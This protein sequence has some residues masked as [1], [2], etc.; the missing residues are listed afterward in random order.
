MVGPNG[1]GQSRTCPTPCAG[2]WA[3]PAPSQLRGG[4]K[5]E[6][7]I[8]RRHAAAGGH[9]LCSAC[10]LVGGQQ[11]PGAWTW[12]ADE[13]TIG[14]RYY[15]SGESEYSINGQICR[16]KDMYELLLDTGLGREGYSV[17]GQGRMAEIVAPSRASAGRSLRKRAASP[18]TATAKTRPSAA[19]PPPRKIW[20]A[21]GISWASWRRG[22]ARWSGRA[23]RPGSFWS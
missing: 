18:N 15:R 10:S 1:S 9:G 23:K 5:M 12:T 20:C 19:W 22:W 7:V 16:L 13:V 2:C 3:R 4:G 6:D 8:F 17:I 21:C 11:P 14:R